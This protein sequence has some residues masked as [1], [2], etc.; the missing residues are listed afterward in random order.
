ML[1]L[2]VPG[3]N[4]PL[5]FGSELNGDD[6]VGIGKCS[7]TGGLPRLYDFSKS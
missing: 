6:R 7:G 2:K 3:R 5:G 4:T 1:R